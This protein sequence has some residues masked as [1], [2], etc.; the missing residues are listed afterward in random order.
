M[1][2]RRAVVL[3]L[4]AIVGGVPLAGIAMTTTDPLPLADKVLVVKS[5]RRLYLYSDG[6][7]IRSYHIVLGHEPRGPKQKEGDGRTPEGDYRLDG[8]NAASRY[9]LSLHVSYPSA[10]DLDNAR[11]RHWQPGGAIM[12]HGLPNIPKYPL[13]YYRTNDWTDGCIALSDDDMVEL[14]LLTRDDTPIEIRP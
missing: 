12:I 11:A 4:L 5:E 3:C 2:Y 7:A 9:F 1:R 14:W 10:R 6:K 13:D 8:R